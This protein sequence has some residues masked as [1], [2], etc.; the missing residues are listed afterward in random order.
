MTTEPIKVLLVDDQRLVNAAVATMLRPEEDLVLKWCGEGTKAI[1]AAREFVPDVILQ[2]LVMPDADGLDIV[3]AMR[4][5]PALR[6][7]PLVVLSGKEEPAVKAEAFARGANDYLVKLPAAVE[8]IARI[9]HHAR[10]YR[11]LLERNAA[12]AALASELAEAAGYVRS[13]LP[14]PISE[15]LQADWI[16]QPSSSLGG[17]AF[18]YHAL[19]DDHFAFYVLDVCGH[20]VGS[21]LLSVSALNTLTACAL[22]GVDFRQPARVLEALNNAYPMERQ[23]QLYFTIWYGVYQRSTRRLTYAGAGH[24]PGVLL[25]AQKTPQLLKGEGLPIGT[26]EGLDYDEFSVTVPAGGRLYL[27][28]DGV[29]EVERPNG[30][31][32]AFEDFVGILASAP[33]GDRA[34]RLAHV[35]RTV[36]GIQGK[37]MFDDDC[38]LM[39][40]AF[41]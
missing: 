40:L 32:L 3:T 29:F 11:A 31:M 15:P 5:D 10:G 34:G 23:N 35:V 2:D 39:E 4:G 19:D 20:G 41:G 13:I 26:F 24:P 7:V 1:E 6:E 12:Y 38:S 9:R 25:D 28:S 14:R 37:E 33:E 8:L 22:P 30:E 27:Y 17:D 18:S 16:F 36:Q 21:A